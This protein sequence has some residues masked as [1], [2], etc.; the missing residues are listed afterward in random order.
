MASTRRL[1]RPLDPYSRLG[2][3][4]GASL[5]DVKRAYR[6]L[7]LE[8]HP[9]RAGSGSVSRFLAVKTAYDW[10]VAHPSFAKQGERRGPSVARP[11][12]PRAI[13]YTQRPDPRS[14][15]AWTVGG[16]PGARWYWEG[17][18]PRTSRGHAVTV[19]SPTGAVPST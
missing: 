8:V 13:R 7:A 14:T 19:A 6:R 15:P 17:F 5:A 9:D 16:W 18:R 10:I 4:P 11:R 1:A 3:A 2:L 12:V